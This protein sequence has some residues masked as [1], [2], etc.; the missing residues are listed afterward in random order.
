[1]YGEEY[2]AIHTSGNGRTQKQMV[3][4]CINGKM[5]IVTKEN[6]ETALK[7]DKGQTSLQMETHLQAHIR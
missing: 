7:M 5:E 4:A 1:M 6:G 2:S 3:M